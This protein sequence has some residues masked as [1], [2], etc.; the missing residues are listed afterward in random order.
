MTNR[1]DGEF[2]RIARL[3]APL[4]ADYPGALGLRD[5]VALIHPPPGRQLIVTTDALV[6]GVHF[7]PE[8]APAA[9]AAKVL[10]VNL[11]DLAAK[12][13]EPFGYSLVT[14]VPPGMSFD[15]MAAFAA[16]L[17][18]DQRRYGIHLLGGDTVS[19]PGPALFTISA[20]GHLPLG[21]G[22]LRS[23]ARPGD[24]VWVTGTLGDAALG[25]ACLQD[26]LVLPEAAAAPLRQ[27]YWW[28]EP[29][30]TAGQVLLAAGAHAGMD[31]S[32]GLVADAR[33]L[34]CASGVA[35]HL[36]APD[37]PLSDSARM[38]L[39]QDPGWWSAVL[40]GGDD[41]ELLVTVPADRADQRLTL[42]AQAGVAITDI[43]MVM[44]GPAG[45]V[46][47]TDGQGRDITPE[48]GGYRHF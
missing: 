29:R 40:A 1:A 10:R 6:A 25:L 5:D 15:W 2:V 36:R 37:M 31:I 21:Q 47:V 28:P 34:A 19:T 33:H 38:A 4:A 16:G 18:A 44:D 3:F 17:A 22:L 20:L 41:Y 39:A 35:L 46:V 42:A 26:R 30:L 14:A 9:I 8:D 32:D 11:S 13:A 43:G 23:L 24:R 7:R 27:R 48:Q 45:A 12:G